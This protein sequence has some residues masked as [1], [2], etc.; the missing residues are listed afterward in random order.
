T[1][2]TKVHPE[3]VEA[4]LLQ[5]PD[6]TDAVVFGMPDRDW[7]ERVVACVVLLAAVETDTLRTFC[8]AR[9]APSQVPKVVRTC[10]TLPRDGFGKIRRKAMQATF[11][12]EVDAGAER[13]DPARRDG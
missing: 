7:G 8:A 5:H 4:A 6:V 13:C 9:L 3:T 12:D 2:G 11:S 1:G 10:T